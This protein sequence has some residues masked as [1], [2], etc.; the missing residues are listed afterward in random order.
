[1]TRN[2]FLSFK[3]SDKNNLKRLGH[4][5]FIR[6]S[7]IRFHNPSAF[8]ASQ[9]RP[10]AG[11]CIRVLVTHHSQCIHCIPSWIPS[12]FLHPCTCYTPLAVHYC[13]LATQ[14]CIH[15]IPAAQQC[16]HCI[17]AT[18]QC[19]HCIPTTQQCIHSLHLTLQTICWLK[20]VTLQSPRAKSAPTHEL[21]E[22]HQPPTG[23][24]TERVFQGGSGRE[25]FG[26]SGG[27]QQWQQEDLSRDQ[28]WG[29]PDLRRRLDQRCRRRHTNLNKHEH[30]STGNVDDL[31]RYFNH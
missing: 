8:T 6:L 4:P 23:S 13:I 28:H 12:R 20:I 25:V 7:R 10:Q 11:P 5:T 3:K 26:Q 22:S 15:C 29:Q 16:I 19:I 27:R 14:Q 30:E 2:G 17:P 24:R 1:M 9:V 18:P 31:N 21:K